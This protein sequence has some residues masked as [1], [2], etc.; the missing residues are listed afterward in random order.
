M[1]AIESD[2]WRLVFAEKLRGQS[3]RWKKYYACSPTWTHD[4]CG[5]CWAEFSLFGG[6]LEEG[7]SVSEDYKWG[8][9]Y[10]WICATCFH[11]L[12][13]IMEWKVID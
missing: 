1:A 11:D 2:D 6:D 13:E 3:F 7:Y 5:A 9:D 4:H 12:A 8:L 10:E